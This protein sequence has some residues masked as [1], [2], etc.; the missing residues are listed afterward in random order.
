MKCIICGK[1]MDERETNC[2]I[3]NSDQNEEI[4]FKGGGNFVKSKMNMS[5]CQMIITNTRLVAVDDYV[6]T[7]MNSAGGGLV[8]GLIG[9]G[10]GKAFDSKLKKTLV[11]INLDTITEIT[12]TK[13]N[14]MVP[15]HTCTITTTDGETIS[16]KIDKKSQ[17]IPTLKELTNK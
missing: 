6:A 14:L 10:L 1:K 8:G 2:P 15:L 11:D 16:F 7:G 4:L 17:F 13:G 9:A 3:C 5:A 12:E